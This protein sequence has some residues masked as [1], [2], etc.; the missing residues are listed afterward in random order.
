M[1]ATG[2]LRI[3]GRDLF[4][5]YLKRL[6]GQP[7]QVVVKRLQRANGHQKGRYL[8]GVLYPV[9]ADE[10]GYRQYE[11]DEV[12]DAVMRE[13]RGLRPEPNPLQLRV[14]YAAMDEDEKSAFI[15]DVRHWAL[16]KFNIVTP[17]AQKVAA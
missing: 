3:D 8:F 17:D 16:M 2:K 6:A 11:V 13:L 4:L 15:E 7:I 5:G 14:S 12:H 1:D 10:L 9:I